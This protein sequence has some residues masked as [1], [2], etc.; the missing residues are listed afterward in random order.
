MKHQYLLSRQ[1]VSDLRSFVRDINRVLQSARNNF[2]FRLDLVDDHLVILSDVDE[3][4]KD[5]DWI[6]TG[7]FTQSGRIAMEVC[8]FLEE[9]RKP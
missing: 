6:G 1:R 9:D 2:D 5:Y 8:E 4:P 7:H 3:L